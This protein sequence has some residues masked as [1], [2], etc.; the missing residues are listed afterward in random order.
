MVAVGKAKRHK[1]KKG[2]K[3]LPLTGVLAECALVV[4]PL[5]NASVTWNRSPETR[6]GFYH[7]APA[8]LDTGSLFASCRL[9]AGDP[10]TAASRRDCIIP[11]KTEGVKCAGDVKKTV[12]LL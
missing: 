10:Q 4:L 12:C 2:K 1:K 5:R 11:H 9:R 7:V 3:T 6:L 8:H